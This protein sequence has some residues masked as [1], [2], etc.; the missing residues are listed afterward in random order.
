MFILPDLWLPNSRDVN[1]IDYRIWG[2][3]QDRV[4]WTPVRDL[5]DLRQRLIDA[6]GKALLAVL[7]MNNVRDFRHE[8]CVDEKE[9]FE[10]W[11]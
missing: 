2:V 8:A 1:Q 11:V 10:H 4:Y 3:A 9:H 7:L 5:A 6:R